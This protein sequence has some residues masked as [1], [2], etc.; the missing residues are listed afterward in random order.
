MCLLTRLQQTWT[1]VLKLPMCTVRKS[2]LIWSLYFSS[3]S[4][5]AKKKV[6]FSSVNC[7]YVHA[8]PYCYKLVTGLSIGDTTTR[9]KVGAGNMRRLGSSASFP[10]HCASPGSEHG[11]LRMRQGLLHWLKNVYV[12]K[13]KEKNVTI[14]WA[15]GK[16]LLTPVRRALNIFASISP[17]F[18]NAFKKTWDQLATCSNNQQ[19]TLTAL[20]KRS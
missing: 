14:P 12:T 4:K 1:L 20:K 7:A 3:S 16:A 18:K 13:T 10:W 17:F 6:W 8:H 5:N 19:K 11:G 15:Y 2:V 9:E